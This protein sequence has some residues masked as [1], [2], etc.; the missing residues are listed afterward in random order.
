MA[1]REY[2]RD[3]AEKVFDLIWDAP[4]DLDSFNEILDK[5]SGES[6]A[7]VGM[8]DYSGPE[9]KLRMVVSLNRH[10]WSP[11]IADWLWE[12][13]RDSDDILDGWTVR[14]AKTQWVFEMS[15]KA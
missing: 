8:S 15:W 1:D 4:F 13:L 2:Q 6:V 9:Q 10:E 5:N 3:T 14:G 11:E 12:A 7:T